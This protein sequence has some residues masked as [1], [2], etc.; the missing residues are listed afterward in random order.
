MSDYMSISQAEADGERARRGAA[1]MLRNNGYEIL[2]ERFQSAGGGTFLVARD[3]E[4]GA[5][6]FVSCRIVEEFTEECPVPRGA[7]EAALF[8]WVSGASGGDEAEIRLDDVQFRLVRGTTAIA[9]YHKG[10]LE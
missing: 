9:R 2:D 3:P 6:A 4:R 5:L 10:A 7:F 8:D 1:R